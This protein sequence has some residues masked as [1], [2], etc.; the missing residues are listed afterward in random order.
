[1]PCLKTLTL[2][3]ARIWNWQIFNVTQ[4][5]APRHIDVSQIVLL[6]ESAVAARKSCAITTTGFR[7]L[8]DE[9]HSFDDQ[10]EELFVKPNFLT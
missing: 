3:V 10:I 1:M 7:T 9:D 2:P 6:S 4:N 8:W 5:L